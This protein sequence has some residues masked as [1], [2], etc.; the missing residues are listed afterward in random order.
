MLHRAVADDR[1]LGGA[2][3]LTD[4]AE[5]HLVRLAGGDARRALTALESAAGVAL[6]QG[7]TDVGLADAERAV[8]APRCATTG[9]ATST[10]TSPAR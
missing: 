9:R 2:V 5:A 6:G 3:T 1:G 8:D 4:E 10:T 7:R